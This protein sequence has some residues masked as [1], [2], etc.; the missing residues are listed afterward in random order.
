MVALLRGINLGAARRVSMAD[1]RACFEELGYEDVETLLQSGNV[2]Y[3]GTDAAASSERRI[4]RA[5]L[6]RT[7]LEIPVAVRTATQLQAVVRRNPLRDHASD[8]KRHH[9]IFLSAKPSASRAAALERKA[10]EPELFELHG[11]ELYVWWPEGV[12]RARLTLPTLERKLGVVGT[13]R[14]WNTVEKLAAMAA[15]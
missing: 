5:L 4:E 9:V 7:G 2:V 11:R 14:N 8:P 15:G 12:H 13:A 6:E 3:R 1:L 10:Y